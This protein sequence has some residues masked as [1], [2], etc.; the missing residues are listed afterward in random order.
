LA[1]ASHLEALVEVKVGRPERA[2]SWLRRAFQLNDTALV[3]VA[4]REMEVL[5]LRLV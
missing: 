5:G 3:E 1:E 4:W 2:L